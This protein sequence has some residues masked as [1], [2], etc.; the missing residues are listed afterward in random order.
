MYPLHLLAP[1]QSWG[2]SFNFSIWYVELKGTTDKALLDETVKTFETYC[3]HEAVRL[4]L[5]HMRENEY[6]EAF[7]AL[8]KKAKVSLEH[9]L[10]TQ[11]HS[12]LVSELHSQ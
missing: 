8:Q 5:K 3:N 2:Y 1:T 4:C 9:P 7:E 10:L 6:M 11:L 12:L